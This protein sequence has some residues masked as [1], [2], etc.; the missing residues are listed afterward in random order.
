MT[1]TI[2]T[3][4]LPQAGT[5]LV[6]PA[7]TEV[8]FVARHLIGT[9]VRGR[10]T[11]VQGTFT[12]AENPAESTLEHGPAS[13]RRDQLGPDGRPDHPWRHQVGRLRPGVPR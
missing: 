12:V 2:S 3:T 1:S 8:G 10:F 9:K 6:D 13:G 5:Y 4:T 7:H 11:D